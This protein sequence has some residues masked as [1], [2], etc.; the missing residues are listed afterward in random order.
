MAIAAPRKPTA[1]GRC[2]KTHRDHCPP[3]AKALQEQVG[4]SARE[5]R[6]EQVVTEIRTH[7]G[8][9]RA[10]EIRKRLNRLRVER[11]RQGTRQDAEALRMRRE[12]RM[13]LRFRQKA[14]PCVQKRRPDGLTQPCHPLF[15]Q[16]R[17]SRLANDALGLN[18]RLKSLQ[19]LQG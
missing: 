8:E 9:T 12:V 10:L 6:L 18:R 3:V 16:R 14:A 4:P 1:L 11:L 13:R 5:K 7:C 2:R 19:V 17:K 15:M